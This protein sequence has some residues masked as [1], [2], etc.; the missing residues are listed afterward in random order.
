MENNGLVLLLEQA[1][2]LENEGQNLCASSSAGLVQQILWSV[3]NRERHEDNE[4]LAS[5]I[6][7]VD[8]LRTENVQINVNHARG[9]IQQLNWSAER[10][11]KLRRSRRVPNENTAICE[12]EF[13]A[14]CEDAC[15]ICLNTHTKGESALTDCGHSFGK[16]CLKSWLRTLRTNNRTCPTCRKSNPNITC[17]IIQPE[18]HP[19]VITP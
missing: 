8:R 3:G 7:L 18:E 16:I 13:N 4:G 2:R 14:L 11:A 12:V 15:A 10:H 1:R 19:N 5:I 9:I 6:R 17:F